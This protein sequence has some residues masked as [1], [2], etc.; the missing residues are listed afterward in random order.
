M[1][2]FITRCKCGDL[3]TEGEGSSKKLSKKRS[4]EKM[5]EELGKL[6][7]LPPAPPGIK[8][9][10]NM[11]PKQSKN[12]IKVHFLSGAGRYY[13][14]IMTS[15]D[16][17]VCECIVFVCN[18][19]IFLNWRLH[20]HLIDREWCCI[21]QNVLNNC[22]AGVNPISRLIQIQQAKKEKEPM[23]TLVEEKGL[24]RAREFYIQVK[25][26]ATYLYSQTTTCLG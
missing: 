22:S 16:S 11:K 10:K 14:L 13:V 15:S 6:P 1:R 26:F 18:V 12:L 4:A 17:V 3:T 23:F 9:K 2:T 5:V 8:P 20:L 25:I 24:P 7:P 19:L 21:L